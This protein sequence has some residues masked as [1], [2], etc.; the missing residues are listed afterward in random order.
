MSPKPGNWLYPTMKEVA[1]EYERA[2]GIVTVPEKGAVPEFP[3]KRTQQ[4][5]FRRREKAGVVRD[6]PEG[7]Q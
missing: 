6:R 7:G 4:E 5:R 1:L 3:R 2:R